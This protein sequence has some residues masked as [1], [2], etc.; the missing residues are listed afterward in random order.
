MP[1]QPRPIL[2]G[3]DHEH[4]GADPARI[5]YETTGEAGTGG[6]IQFDT[7]NEGGWLQI[8]TNDI[9][10]AGGSG[11]LGID[12]EDWSGGGI[13]IKAASGGQLE[14]VTN[15]GGDIVIQPTGNLRLFG[16]ASHNIIMHAL[17]TSDP[18]VAGALWVDSSGFL[19]VS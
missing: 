7:D 14:L 19:K 16:G 2:H 10:E 18:G 11:G 3:R 1:N 5:V 15:G 4:G 12:L 8:T 6:G 13:V 17:P 9:T